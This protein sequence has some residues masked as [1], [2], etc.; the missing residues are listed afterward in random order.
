MDYSRIVRGVPC[1]KAGLCFSLIQE[2]S[3]GGQG[4]LTTYAEDAFLEFENRANAQLK[5]G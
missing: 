1:A 5:T 4:A 2:E 3:N